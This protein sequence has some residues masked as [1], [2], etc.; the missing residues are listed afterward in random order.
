MIVASVSLKY[1]QSNSIAFA[2]NGRL[3][4]LSAGQQN[5]LDSIRLAGEKALL[6]FIRNDPDF[7]D[8]IDDE[9][10]NSGLNLSKQERLSFIYDF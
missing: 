5:R 8:K 7:N 6:W 1:A 9:I 4:G 2:Y 10:K 3:I